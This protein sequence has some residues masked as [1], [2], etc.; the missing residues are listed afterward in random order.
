MSM[1]MSLVAGWEIDNTR[2]SRD[3][4]HNA[5]FACVWRKLA[6]QLGRLYAEIQ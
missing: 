5:V 1:C 6:S 2:S 3:V 4:P